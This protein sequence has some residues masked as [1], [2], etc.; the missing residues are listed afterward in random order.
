MAKNSSTVF[1]VDDSVNGLNVNSSSYWTAAGGPWSA[2]DTRTFGWA[3]IPLVIV[4]FVSSLC[5][6]YSSYHHYVQP[7]S[8]SQRSSAAPSAINILIFSL[9]LASFFFSTFSLPVSVYT[10]V[11]QDQNPLGTLA[12]RQ[13]CRFQVLY[14]TPAMTV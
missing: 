1:G 9:S 4:G 3:T 5:C 12:F 14:K 2:Q 6:M 13:F 10:M 8:T 11:V 7:S